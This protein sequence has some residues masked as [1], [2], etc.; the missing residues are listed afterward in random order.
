MI[1]KRVFPVLLF[2]CFIF[3][4][5]ASSDYGISCENEPK[6]NM[7]GI[8]IACPKICD[9]VCKTVADCPCNPE[10]KIDTCWVPNELAE[11]MCAKI[12]SCN[13]I[14]RFTGNVTFDTPSYYTSWSHLG[15]TPQVEQVGFDGRVCTKTEPL[16][17]GC[18]SCQN[19]CNSESCDA[20]FQTLPRPKEYSLTKNF[21]EATSN[22]LTS[23]CASC[24]CCT[25]LSHGSCDN[26]GTFCDIPAAKCSLEVKTAVASLFLGDSKCKSWFDN[27]SA[28]ITTSIST[29]CHCISEMENDIANFNPSGEYDC[30][31]HEKTQSL[32]K[33]FQNCQNLAPCSTEDECQK[34]KSYKFD[35]KWVS[36]SGQSCSLLP[37]TNE[38]VVSNSESLLDANLPCSIRNATKL[39]EIQRN[40]NNTRN[41][42][43]TPTSP[44]PS[45]SHTDNIPEFDEEN[46]IRGL[47]LK[48]AR[49]VRKSPLEADKQSVI[50]KIPPTQET[51]LSI[52]S[53]GN[54]I[55]HRHFMDSNSS[56]VNILLF[57]TQFADDGYI[58]EWSLYSGRSGIVHAQVF[59][60]TDVPRYSEGR[61]VA[62]NDTTIRAFEV[63]GENVLEVTGLGE[64]HFKIPACQKIF[65]Q[66]GDYIGFYSE[67]RGVVSFSAGGETVLYRYGAPSSPT[68][69]FLR[70]PPFSRKIFDTQGAV[71]FIGN[72]TSR[73]YSI[74]I[75][76]RFGKHAMDSNDKDNNFSDDE[77]YGRI[78][79]IGESSNNSIASNRTVGSTFGCHNGSVYWCV[80]QDR[81]IECSINKT[82]WIR[83][84]VAKPSQS[85][86]PSITPSA[87]VT[88]TPSASNVLGDML[89]NPNFGVDCAYCSGGSDWSSGMCEIGKNQSPISIH[90]NE[91]ETDASTT[92]FFVP[93]YRSE[94]VTILHTSYAPIVQQNMGYLIVD[95]KEYDAIG[96][97]VRSPAE[98]QIQNVERADVEF[99]IVHSL[100]SSPTEF[101]IV[102]VMIDEG[103]DSE[104]SPQVTRFFDSFLR[105]S[106]QPKVVEDFNIGEI[107]DNTKPNVWY[108]GSFTVPPCKEGVTWAVQMGA[109]QLIGKT[110]LHKLNSVYKNN[111]HFANGRGNNRV[112]QH[113]NLRKPILR[114]NCGVTGAIACPDQNEI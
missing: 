26:T 99:Q 88:P 72:G 108:S 82:L 77:C 25:F 75:K 39:Y 6:K 40:R 59:R 66:K 76:G 14:S 41:L 58:D 74:G 53:L 7:M 102:S 56:V 95:G 91:V 71:I 49:D 114:S 5:S 98:H 78:L 86:Q 46:D 17:S 107:I 57:C 73:T 110:Q 8:D 21:C 94:N 69:G 16:T 3:Y 27:Y 113:L 63:V 18:F 62:E 51:D 30:I 65:V 15:N 43:S 50:T 19:E 2:A 4:T 45:P 81:M 61:I 11:E 92:Q 96:L 42:S 83:K 111:L 12:S 34:C 38:C 104:S 90:W 55:E 9:E 89:T 35:G 10:R 84:C 1:N 13:I 70:S 32:T 103:L 93:N 29:T 97:I 37:T 33:L 28:G 31:V 24:N 100:R 54:A 109:N 105:N 112:L 64:Q 68:F 85:P 52:T 67:K 48:L 22:N 23:P 60:E 44:S 87:S 36:L 101:L 79:P 47:T 20:C 106:S 80:N